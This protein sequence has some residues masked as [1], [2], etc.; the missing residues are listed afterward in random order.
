MRELQSR[1]LTVLVNKPVPGPA[2]CTM[3]P[4]FPTLQ[5]RALCAS[6]APVF[7]GEVAMG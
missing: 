7:E 6:R 2:H 1:M 5:V 3:Q 4:N